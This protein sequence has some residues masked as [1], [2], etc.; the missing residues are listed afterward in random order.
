MPRQPATT[1]G[2]IGVTD[3]VLVAL[4]RIIRAI[5]LHSRTLVTRFG[6]TGPQLTLLRAL[7][8]GGERSVGDLAKAVSLSHATTTGI[9][10]R[11][12]KVGLVRRVRCDQDRR[13]VL[14]SLTPDGEKALAQTPPMLQEHFIAEFGRLEDWEQTLILSSLQRIVSLMEARELDATPMLAT[15]PL[16]AP[17]EGIRA[18]LAPV[19]RQRKQTGQKRM[20][21]ARD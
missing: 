19:D 8:A 3:Q 5:D 7:P 12:G 4:R 13:R 14:V 17:I 2:Q 15:G 10:E 1:E 21:R 6:L 9:V 18:F 16:D 20:T 11:L